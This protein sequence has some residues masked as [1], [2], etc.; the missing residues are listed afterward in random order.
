MDPHEKRPIEQEQ[1]LVT[2]VNIEVYITRKCLSGYPGLAM[3]RGP[4]RSDSTSPG[5]DAY[6]KNDQGN[7]QQR[8]KNAAERLTGNESEQPQYKH[9]NDN[10]L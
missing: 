4:L 6:D 9:Y 8:M 1:D 3:S 5:K 7:K 2:Q 10:G